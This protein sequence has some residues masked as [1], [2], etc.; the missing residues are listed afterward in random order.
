MVSLLIVYTKVENRKGIREGIRTWIH[1]V[2]GQRVNH[3]STVRVCLILSVYQCYHNDS[4]AFEKGK[5]NVF[6]SPETKM[7]CAISPVRVG[8]S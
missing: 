1:G 2:T 4:L 3:W 6:G 8:N 7:K 5:I